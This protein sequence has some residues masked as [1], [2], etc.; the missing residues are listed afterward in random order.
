MPDTSDEIADLTDA[1]AA[2]PASASIDGRSASQH[3][4]PDLIALENH[5]AAQTANT[6]SNGHFG[7]RFTTLIPPGCG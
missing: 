4:I 1:A 6:P 3:R 7:L 5:R 2:G